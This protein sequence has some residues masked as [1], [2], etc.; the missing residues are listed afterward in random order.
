MMINGTL[1][2]ILLIQNM[3]KILETKNTQMDDNCH[4]PD[5]KTTIINTFKRKKCLEMIF[6]ATVVCFIQF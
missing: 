5:I 6:L 4:I 3:Q 2:N 1:S